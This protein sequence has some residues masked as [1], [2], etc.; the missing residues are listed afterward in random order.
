MGLLNFSFFGD[1][2]HRVFDYKPIYYD[3]EKDELK[4]KFGKVDGSV[5]NAKKDGT[6]VPGTSLQGA[7]KNGGYQKTRGANRAQSIIG[8]VGL[9]LFAVVLIMIAKFYSLL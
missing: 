2:E 4:Q 5:D 1:Q 7:F 8:I 9:I 3:R 6:Y